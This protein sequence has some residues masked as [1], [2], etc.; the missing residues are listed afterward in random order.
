MAGVRTAKRLRGG[1]VAAPRRIRLE[2][3]FDLLAAHRVE[4]AVR[5]ARSLAAAFMLGY[6]GATGY[7]DW[8]QFA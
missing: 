3:S 4:C 5:L 6:L 2:R 1:I 7:V 8:R